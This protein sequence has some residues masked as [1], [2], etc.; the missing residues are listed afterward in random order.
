MTSSSRE[1][2]KYWAKYCYWLLSKLQK[3]QRATTF[4]FVDIFLSPFSISLNIHFECLYRPIASGFAGFSCQSHAFNWL[5]KISVWTSP[6]HS[7]PWVIWL[8]LPL[9]I[10]RWWCFWN[11]SWATVCECVLCGCVYCLFIVK[12]S[13]PLNITVRTSCSDPGSQPAAGWQLLGF[14]NTHARIFK[15]TCAHDPTHH[16][17]FNQLLYGANQLGGAGHLGGRL[18]GR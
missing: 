14:T 6:Y 5:I 2:S 15:H 1:T 11:V 7:S 17:G 8:L 18:Q 16:L 13:D 3:I 12:Y 4:F 9:M 10:D